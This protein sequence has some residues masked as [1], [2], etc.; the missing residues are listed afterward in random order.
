MIYLRGNSKVVIVVFLLIS[1]GSCRQKLSEIKPKL[2]TEQT[3]HDTDDPAIWINTLKPEQSIIFGTDKDEINGGVYA[4]NLD[5]KI[6]MEKSIVGLS[7]PNNVDIGYN[8][9]INDSLKTDILAF[10]EREK[11][12]IR[13]YSVPAM[14]PLDNGGLKV[15]KDEPNMAYRRPMGIALYSDRLSDKTYVIVNIKSRI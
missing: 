2:I 8:V 3:P 1:F 11:H 7:Y 9:K 12:Q 15:F 13:I 4:F 5:G 10:T 14:K 6:V